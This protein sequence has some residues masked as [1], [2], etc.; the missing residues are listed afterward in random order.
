MTPAQILVYHVQV[1]ARVSTYPKW[2]QRVE[3]LFLADNAAEAISLAGSFAAA[4]NGNPIY[5]AVSCYAICRPVIEKQPA[6]PYSVG[7]AYVPEK[8]L[9]TIG[10]GKHT[11]I[12]TWSQFK[13]Q[14]ALEDAVSQAL[15]GKR[16]TP[17]KK[18][19]PASMMAA[20]RV[21]DSLDVKHP[22]RE[23]VESM[24]MAVEREVMPMKLLKFIKDLV[25][26]APPK[27]ARQVA[28]FLTFFQT[29]RDARNTP[30]PLKPG[31]I[32][33]KQIK[34]EDHS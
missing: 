6:I 27:K 18:A 21:L 11:K 15:V 12:F 31:D 10:T 29:K 1:T 16:A 20:Y 24:A 5:V 13:S 19:S 26:F 28:K 25:K 23:L 34:V 7:H 22:S 4:V 14:K 17:S 9:A 2:D 33:P 32:K 8:I 3:Q 30:P